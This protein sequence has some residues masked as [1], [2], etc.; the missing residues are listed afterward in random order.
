MYR[1]MGKKG[2]GVIPLSFVSP[3]PFT[4]APVPPFFLPSFLPACLQSFLL[5][6]FS[7]ILPIPS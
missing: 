2:E 4:L 7:T 1:H 3:S 6:L 5:S